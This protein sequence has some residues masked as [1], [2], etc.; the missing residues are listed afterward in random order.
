[1]KRHLQP[2]VHRILVGAAALVTAVTLAACSGTPGA[3][4]STPTAGG[5]LTIA[6]SE[7]PG[8]LDP[9]VSSAYA[10]WQVTS[11]IYGSLLRPGE[12]G[13]QQEG[14][15]AES[16][17]QPDD[18]TYDFTLRDG[19][20][21]SDG[22]PVTSADVKYSFDRI[23]D[24]ATAS[25]WAGIFK[26]ISSIETPDDKTVIF[27]LSAP[28]APFLSYLSYPMYTPILEQKT[29]EANNGSL[30]SAAMG[31]GPYS[32]VSFTPGGEVVLTKNTHYWMTGKPLINDIDMKVITD[33]TARLSA[34]KTGTVQAAQFNDPRLS[35][36]VGNA[37]GLTIQVPD[38]ESWEM[39]IALNQTE[40]PFNNVDVRRAI[41]EGIDRDALIKL[42]LNGQGSIGSKIPPAS[43]PYGF[44]GDPKD[45]PYSTYDP[46]DAKQLLASA[47]YPDGLTVDLNIPTT[48]LPEQ[49]ASALKDQ[50]AKIGVTLNIVETDQTSLLNAFIAT[51]YSGMAMDPLVWQPDPDADIHDIW[52]SDSSINLGKFSDADLDAA[53]EAGRSTSDVAA[54]TAAYQKAQLIV[55]Q[56]AYMVFPFEMKSYSL[57]TRDSVV[58]LINDD[59][60]LLAYDVI[61]ASVTGT[62]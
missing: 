39:S 49:T 48:A 61:N 60:G 14:D 29:V 52:T 50:L 25:P 55:A 32:L 9:N 46:D 37:P 40:A 26:T 56:N 27:H 8:S 13:K 33:D 53:I 18:L 3:G 43:A 17:T 54:R 19:V 34:V 59:S 62:N 41:S 28:F 2:P 44:S 35:D 21:F 24:P 58:G 6:L 15:V 10:S 7:D 31:T 5:T 12:D 4:T 23:L 16:W 47:G 45:L 36:L 22:T 20:E 30:A 1:M 38:S 57:V 51:S 11:Y 42:V